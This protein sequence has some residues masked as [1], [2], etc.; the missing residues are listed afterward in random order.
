MYAKILSDNKLQYASYY[1]IN[2]GKIILNPQEQNYLEAGY[3][4]VVVGPVSN[5][6]AG[7]KIVQNI[8]FDN[9]KITISY[10]L[11]DEAD[12]EDYNNL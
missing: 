2:N 12:N 9:E 8:S 10:S 3:F 6:E 7:K 5:L 4:P 1:V 11:E